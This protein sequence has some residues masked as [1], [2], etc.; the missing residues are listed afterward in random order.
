MATS[1]PCRKDR[2][3]YQTIAGAVAGLGRRSCSRCG[4]VQI[5]LRTHGDQEVTGGSVFFTRRPTLFSLRSETVLEDSTAASAGFG[6]KKR[7]RH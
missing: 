2:H 7:G 6:T 3:K 4:S 5:D 1:H